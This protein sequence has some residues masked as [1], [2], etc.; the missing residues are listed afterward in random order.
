[1]CATTTRSR[2]R[3]RLRLTVTEAASAIV[4][5]VLGIIG[6]VL[7]SAPVLGFTSA[8]ANVRQCPAAE[9]RSCPSKGVLPAG[10]SVILLCWTAGEWVV[11][12]KSVHGSQRWYQVDSL[13]GTGYVHSSLV[14]SEVSVDRCA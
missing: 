14:V 9:D 5:A 13:L 10:A 1:M 6:S 8:V 4:A 3:F 2:S 11:P 7:P 12:P